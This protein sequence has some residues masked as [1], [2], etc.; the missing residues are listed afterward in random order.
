MI[1]SAK[2]S[3]VQFE[4]LTAMALSIPSVH[5]RYLFISRGAFSISRNK[6]GPIL[7]AAHAKHDNGQGEDTVHN[8]QV[9]MGNLTGYH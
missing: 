9:G 4:N 1:S 7:G 2:L 6:A 3:R 5:P 8:G